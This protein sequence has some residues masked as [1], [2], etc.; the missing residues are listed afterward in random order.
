MKLPQTAPHT[1]VR[2]VVLNNRGD[3]EGLDLIPELDRVSPGHHL[4]QLYRSDVDRLEVA[5]AFI[6]QGLERGQKVIYVAEEDVLEAVRSGLAG[7]GA[8]LR[9]ALR[10]G[11]LSLRSPEE[12]Y[13][14]PAT[15][16]LG[17]TL[18]VWNREADS[19]AGGRWTC[20]RAAGDMSWALEDPSCWE[21]LI[22]YEAEI[23]RFPSAQSCILLCQYD[24]RGFDANFQLS[25]LHTHPRM[26]VG[27]ELYDNIY[28][29]PPGEF[30][31]NMVPQSVLEYHLE[32]LRDRKQALL[33]IQSAREYAEAI[34]DT[35]REPL[36]VLDPDLRVVTANRSFYRTFRTKPEETEGRL[37]YELGDR[38][39]D[40]PPLRR[41]LEEIIPGNTF[42]EDFEVDTE[43]PIIGHRNMLLNARRIH[44]RDE[45]T[46]LILLSIEDVTE[47]RKA[48]EELRRREDYFQHLVENAFDAV[49][50]LDAGGR[51]VY[52]SPS[53]KEVLGWEPEELLGKTPFEFMH[54][55]DLPEV[56]KTFKRGLDNPGT[57]QHV[58]HRFRRPDGSWRYVESVGASFLQDPHVEG[59]VINCRDITERRVAEERLQ[60]LN[61]MFRSLGAD[62]LANME[63]ALTACRDILSGDLAAYA[64]PEDGK[65]SILTTEPGEEGFL[66]LEQ[67]TRFTGWPLLR[68]PNQRPLLL[69]GLKAGEGGDPLAG[70]RFSRYSFL[71]HPVSRPGKEPGV[72]ALYCR[73]I[74]EFGAEDLEVMAVLARTLSIEEERLA[75]EENLKNF[76]DIASHE[77]RHPI[78]LIKGYALSL[79]E[80][81]HNLEDAQ[82]QEMLS[83]IDEGTERLTRL[84][85]GLLD[86]SRIERGILQLDTVKVEVL[87]LIQK[88]V[89]EMRGADRN[90]VLRTLGETGSCRVDP[91]RIS[92]VLVILLENAFK[93]SPYGEVVELEVE[94]H[95]SHLLFSVMDRGP[96][97][98]EEKREL[99]FDRFY[100]V[101]QARYH[102]KPGLGMG[103]YIAREIVERHGGRLWYEP[104]SGG[105]SVFRF[106][107]PR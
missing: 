76:I 90:L 105:G 15:F 38:Q 73:D 6:H 107:V 54:P 29:V 103:L 45:R 52:A 9:R 95:P 53:V 1:A 51:H 26:L 99:I 69:T 22:V 32:E 42:F 8:D 50:L 104:R 46:R 94:A 4:C 96:G 20:L 5:C 44:G 14:A 47:R 98:E 25:L 82:A 102:S 100:Q 28:Y 60:R 55:D 56:M 74:R 33:E 91:E 84:V 65:L 97:V 40:I 63:A 87:P 83:A 37:V 19:L 2:E 106:T 31:E 10:S 23:N 88:V 13:G 77:L 64:R 18:D 68:D 62:F 101:E 78:T 66:L 49:T 80:R 59:V 79:K 93:F 72:L 57:V 67:A 36:L 86:L 3:M 61:R 43:F 35:V 71:G 75:R 24:A 30:L 85:E 7:S 11:Q 12:V 27:K 17:A 34:V 39:W 92:Q 58:I 89:R 81:W 70:R 21:R 16:D 48:E 41:L